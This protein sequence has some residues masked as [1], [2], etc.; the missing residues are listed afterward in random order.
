M[1][2][3]SK[4]PSCSN[5]LRI[6]SII[7]SDLNVISYS[8]FYFIFAFFRE[9]VCTIA[10]PYGRLQSVLVDKKTILVAYDY[11]RGEPRGPLRLNTTANTGDCVNCNSCVVVCPTG[12]DIRNGTQM[13][14]VNCTAC[15][16]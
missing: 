16:D 6:G 15:M 4:Y 14:C 5:D 13:E 7:S 11:K 9:Q 10:C 2:E 12:I 1:G 8:V 3:G